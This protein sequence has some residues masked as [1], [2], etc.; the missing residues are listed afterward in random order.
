[1]PR[2]KPICL[3][4]RAARSKRLPRKRSAA[5]ADLADAH[6]QL[7]AEVAQAYMQLRDGQQR[8]G[9][10]QQS[11][12]V[13][14]RA[15]TLTQQRRERGVASD[16]EVERIRTQVENTRAAL[17]PLDEQVTEALD[18]LAALTG[19]EPGALDAE[20]T[21]VAPLPRLPEVTP[22]GDPASLLR[23]RPDIRAAELRLALEERTDRRTHR[24]LVSEAHADWRSRLQRRGTRPPG[25]KRELHVARRAAAAMECARLRAARKRT[26]E[27]ARAGFDEAP[28]KYESTVLGALRD[29]NVALSRYGHQ[30]ESVV[31]L[32]SVETSATTRRSL[33]SSAI[34]LARPPPWSGSMPNARASPPSRTESPRMRI[35]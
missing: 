11:V 32:R 12:E 7:S 5:Q 35:C 28:A 15:L 9:L 4:A 2:G 1:M 29:A 27:Q 34:A 17:I 25:A 23:R 6:V 8:L 31:R 30:R 19:R 16:L 26:S 22:V 21:A 10:V 20:L 3:A 13:E 33:P 18:Q 24:R 14:D